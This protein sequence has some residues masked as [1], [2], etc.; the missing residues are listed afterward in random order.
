[1]DNNRDQQPLT[2]ASDST[3]QSLRARDP[4][5][6]EFSSAGS[7]A[8]G[9]VLR[10]WPAAI[11]L[12]SMLGLR[13]ILW[14][15][16]SPSLPLMLV[17]FM[18]SGALSVLL[19]LWWLFA[20]RAAGK[21]KLAVFA[22]YVVIAVVAA[23]ALDRSLRGMPIALF[24]LP[25]GTAAFGA[26]LLMTATQPRARLVITM[27]TT[28]I[29]FG[30][31]TAVQVQGFNGKFH[32]D[33]LWRWQ[34]TAEENFLANVSKRESVG[35]A[36]AIDA[37]ALQSPEWSG[38][39]GNDRAGV[40][41]GLTLEED[42]D[43]AAPKELWRTQV[44]PAWS[45]FA[46]AGN[47]LFTQE[48]RGENE[49]V[50]CLDAESGRVVWEYDYPSRFWESIGGAGPRATPTVNA[51]GVFALGGNGILLRLDAATGESLWRRDLTVDAARQP[52]TWGFASSP[53][54][55][56]GKVVVHAGGTNDKGILAYD[57]ETGEPRWAAASGPHSYSS[58]QEATFF[59]Q[60]GI[61]MLTDDGVQFL[62]VEDGS[63]IWN[64]N[65]RQEDYRVVQPLVV[66]NSI[67]VGASLGTGA[68][69]ITLDRSDDQWNI[70]EDWESRNLKPDF[71]DSVFYQGHVYGF[72]SGIFSC[73]DFAS[74]QRDWKRGRYGNGQVILLADAGQLLISSEKGEVVLV[75]ATPE[76]LDELARLDAFDGKT[77]NHPVL[78]RDRLYIRNAEEAACYKMPVR[79]QND[80]PGPE[81]VSL[82]ERGAS[83]TDDNTN[84][85]DSRQ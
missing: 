51:E 3:Q 13:S 43:S 65:W 78:V 41:T 49:A 9:R 61:L 50:V 55:I 76:R 58:A 30:S 69:R 79:E 1:M 85:D 31:W 72:D 52:P 80:S 83:A 7:G 47:R 12:L 53:L 5:S 37:T 82:S 24:V 77:W 2:E 45:S 35:Q 62:K 33:F 84:R 4:E 39:R 27:L 36:P 40:V 60:R 73:I 67:L 71:N 18:G 44:G 38:F 56:D 17:G 70:S 11:L 48:Q 26:G 15:I 8:K 28:L 23:L 10:W 14:L 25:A 64:Y 42:W 46:V 16:E 32:G 63:T 54:V 29:G 57:V 74:G 34:P 81:L 6:T 66:D 22:G 20:S 68:R 19:L 75:K 21:E 59:D